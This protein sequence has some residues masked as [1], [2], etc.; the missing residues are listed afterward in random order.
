MFDPELKWLRMCRKGC[1]HLCFSGALLD[2]VFFAIGWHVPG[3]ELVGKFAFTVGATGIY[4][5]HAEE[6]R[7][8]ADERAAEREK[9]E[10]A[11]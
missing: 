3:I 11:T 9:T 8:A 10:H 5:L 7:R 4:L 6:A 1:E 2:F